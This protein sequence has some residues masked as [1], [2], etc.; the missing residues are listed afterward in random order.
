[1]AVFSESVLPSSSGAARS[2]DWSKEGILE[3]SVYVE[4]EEFP[5][6]LALNYDR[7]LQPRARR[8]PLGILFLL[9]IGALLLIVVSVHLL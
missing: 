1:M 8:F 9:A 7:I 2:G 5:A 4:D 6:A 3:G